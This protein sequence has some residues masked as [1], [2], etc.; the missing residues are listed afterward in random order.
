MKLKVENLTKYY[1]KRNKNGVENINFEVSNGEIYGLFGPKGSGKTTIIKCIVGLLKPTKGIVKIDGNETDFRT[2]KSIAYVPE[3]FSYYNNVSVLEILNVTKRI[4]DV[5]EKYL[6]DLTRTFDLKVQ[7]KFDDLSQEE[8]SILSIVLSLS[9]EPD[10]LIIDEINIEIN[11]VA[12]EFFYEILL[13][14]KHKDK[15]ILLATSC[16]SHVQAVCDK[17]GII[18][19][20]SLLG[21]YSVESF[22]QNLIKK[23]RIYGLENT[24]LPF[25]NFKRIGRNVEIVVKESLIKGTLSKI[26]NL[27][28][29]DLEI[30]T[31]K[32]EEILEHFLGGNENV[33]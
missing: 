15:T 11:D 4:Y 20:G 5:N 32:A 24:E 18:N 1:D 2:Y 12:K 29:R 27:R 6:A 33:I 22:S 8:K 16:M 19:E 30:L 25:K 7:K 13:D 31:P 23:I 14:M 21:E 17:I 26:L 10:L 28:Y 9:Y 3:I